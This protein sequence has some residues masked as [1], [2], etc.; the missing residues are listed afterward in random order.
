MWS[1]LNQLSSE[2]H[3]VDYLLMTKIRSET[4]IK[5]ATEY[6]K[7]IPPDLLGEKFDQIRLETIQSFDDEW[8]VIL[9]YLVEA[10]SE[11]PLLK[12]LGTFRRYRE[13]IVSAETGEV[14]SLRSVD[15]NSRTERARPVA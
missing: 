10:S 5:I 4:A 2:F 3:T 9:S 11:N 1:G 14:L 7:G 13:I 15:D 6:L 12:A 8:V